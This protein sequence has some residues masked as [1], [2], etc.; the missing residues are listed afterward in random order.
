MLKKA[1]IFLVLALSYHTSFAQ[2]L[3]DGRYSITSR[4]SGLSLDVAAGST[5]DGAN[6][7]QWAYTEGSHQ[8]FDVAYMG[9]G[10][11]SIRA[12]HS[13]K[14]LDV[15]AFSTEDGGEIRQW[16][17]LSGDNQLWSITAS[18]SGFYTITSKWSGMSLDVWEWSTQ[19][20]GDIRQWSSTGATNQQWSFTPVQPVCTNDPVDG[21]LFSITSFASGK[22]LDVAAGSTSNGGNI[23]LWGYAGSANQHF[24][25]RAV[26]NTYWTISPVNSNLMLDVSGRSTADGANILQWAATGAHNQQWQLKRST[27]GAYNIVSRSSGKSVT[28]GSTNNGA[29]I[30]QSTDTASGNQRW[31]FT[32]IDAC[33]SNPPTTPPSTTAVSGFASMPG[34]NGL[35]TTTGGGNA[36]PITVSTCSALTSALASSNPA[37]IHLANTT[38]D[39]RTSARTQVACP[40]TCPNNSSETFYR[41]PVGTQTC[42]ELGSANN[43]TVNRSRNEARLNVASNKTVIGLGANSKVLGATFNLSNASNVILQNF[44][45]EDVNPGLI[46]AGDA[47]TLANSN[48][49]WLDHL[50]TNLISDGHVDIN[51]SRNVTLSWNHFMGWNTAVCDN[52]HHY[53]NGVSNSV[54]TFHHNFWDTNS[55]RNPKLDGTSTR[56]HLYNNYWK[57]ISYFSTA[58]TNGAQALMHANYFENSAK[59][60]WADSGYINANVSTNVYTGKS[61]TD[62]YRDTGNSVLGDVTMYSYS[63]DSAANLPNLVGNNAGPK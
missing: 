63:L 18:D 20:G 21:G 3:A 56:A 55:G 40:I 11:Y 36:T 49:I 23:Q 28:V 6:I 50:R 29:N 58:A 59:P 2:S 39:C 14:S 37:V 1:L 52:Q 8:Q 17:Y 53:T 46:E 5:A 31:V 27:T 32:R 43:A 45:I 19:N 44:T 33:S 62:A 4:H 16:E 15:Y 61:A 54:V 41:V 38:I 48:H 24:N 51:D 26:D 25:L 7:Q 22:S 35:S 34:N 30:Y 57:D 12:A 13:G 47:V 10:Y 60:H 9:S 42:T